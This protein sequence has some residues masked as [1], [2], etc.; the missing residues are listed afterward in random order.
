ML[1]P[2]VAPKSEAAFG[3]EGEHVKH[4]ALEGARRGGATPRLFEPIERRPRPPRLGSRGGVA[5]RAPGIHEL[6]GVEVE[7]R[8]VARVRGG[9]QLVNSDADRP[10]LADV[11]ALVC[12]HALEQRVGVQRHPLLLCLAHMPVQAARHVGSSGPTRVEGREQQICRLTLKRTQATLARLG[13]AHHAVAD[14]V[15]SGHAR[16]HRAA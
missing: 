15:V 3:C 9:P 5:D 14:E 4:A 8:R 1:W 2:P 12:E 7:P 13:P 10:L 6:S 16:V 11:A